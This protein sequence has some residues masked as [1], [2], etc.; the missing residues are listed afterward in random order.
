MGRILPLPVLE[1]RRGLAT[2][3][4]TENVFHKSMIKNNLNET[5]VGLEVVLAGIAR[6][7]QVLMQWPAFAAVGIGDVQDCCIG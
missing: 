5:W 2:A 4:M 1:R 3:A 6:A 7:S